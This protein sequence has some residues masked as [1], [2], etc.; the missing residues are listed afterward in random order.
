VEE[1]HH[2]LTVVVAEDA[3]LMREGLVSLL[4]S[5]G[6]SVV[7]T[8]SDAPGL[9]RRVELARPDVAI[10]DIRMPPTHTDEGL[11]AASQIRREH[12]ATAVLVLS[13]HLEPRYALDLID[14]NPTRT[15]YLLKDRVHHAQALADAVHRVANGECVVDPA[16]VAELLGRARPPGPLD[17]LTPRETQV[18]SMVA[19]GLS[20]KAIT[21]Q[22]VISPR[23]LETHLHHVFDKLGILGTQQFHRRVQAV[24]AYLRG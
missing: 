21:E 16:I 19:Q 4:R 3:A 7:G 17:D 8:A 1:S 24:L 14:R 12:P 10:V 2:A 18:L 9:L 11:A 13:H 15:G 22:L 20:N 6:L 23:T 5:A